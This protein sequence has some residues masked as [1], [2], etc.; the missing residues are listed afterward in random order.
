[1]AAHS[2]FCSSFLPVLKFPLLH[3][4]VWN[5]L[6]SPCFLCRREADLYVKCPEIAFVFL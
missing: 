1:M 6:E 5:L 4:V 2:G 3:R